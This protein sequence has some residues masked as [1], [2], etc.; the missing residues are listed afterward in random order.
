MQVYI[1]IASQ[2]AHG[3]SPSYLISTFIMKYINTFNFYYLFLFLCFFPSLSVES[4]LFLQAQTAVEFITYICV[5]I[6]CMS[7]ESPTVEFNDIFS[8]DITS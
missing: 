2:S 5:Y 7:L 4:N 8:A 1:V 6:L 3:K